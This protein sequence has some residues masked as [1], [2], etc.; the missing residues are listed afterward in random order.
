MRKKIVVPLLIICLSFIPIYSWS[1]K[2]EIRGKIL[3]KETLE[4]IPYSS[5]SV[6]STPIG[7]CSNYQ[8]EFI[9][10]YP[11]SLINSKLLI[12]CIGYKTQSL[13]LESLNANDITNIYLDPASYE[14][15]EV[16]IRPNQMTA[17]DFVKQVIKNMHKNYVRSP[18][19]MEGF[20]RDKVFNLYDNKNVRLTEAAVEIVKKEFGGENRADRIKI[21]EIRNSYNYSRLGSSLKEK[22]NQIFWGYSK[23]NPAY[24]ILQSRDFTDPTTLRKLLKNELYSFNFS[25]MTIYD[26]KPVQIIDIK[27]EYVEFMFMRAKSIYAHNLIR[28]YIDTESYAMLK[29]EFYWIDKHPNEMFHSGLNNS[30]LND[31]IIG[32]AIKQYEKINE[33]YYLKYASFRG[34]IHD[35]PDE[36]EMGKTLYYNE[37]ELLIN[38]VVTNKKDFDRIKHRDLLEKDVSL[39]D[40]KYVYDPS[41]WKNYNILIDKPLDTAVQKDLEKEAPLNNQFIDA[42]VKNSKNPK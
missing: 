8:G 36:N 30:F 31:S 16:T 18:Y 19:Y 11:D 14:I 34:R 5:I 33:N 3:D 21:F 12:S 26:G 15:S 6:K 17:S 13:E 10:Y 32:F 40:M 28:L 42:G 24:I 2:R 35:Q 41:F 22:F 23:N 38:K 25:G 1:Q 20:I 7:T 27:E 39:W 37:T 4:A 9:F 29:T